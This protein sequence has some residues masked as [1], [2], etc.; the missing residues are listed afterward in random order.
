[1]TQSRILTPPLSKS[2]A[3]RALI[4]AHILQTT[5]PDQTKEAKPRDVEL[6]ESGLETLKSLNSL[7]SLKSKTIQINC[8]DGGAPFRFLL[9]QAAVHPGARVE[10]VGTRR[11]GERPHDPLIA[12]LRTI[13]GITITQ[14]VP[15]PVTVQSPQCIPSPL[16]FAIGGKE[17]SQFAS[18]LVL[19]AARL[20]VMGQ[21]ARV[22]REGPATS[23]GYFELTCSW[24]ERTGFRLER[25]SA[26]VVVKA[27]T[28]SRP[29]PSIPGDWSSLGYLLALSW[30]SGLSV[31]R[32]TL[33]TG[34][35]DEVVV[36]HLKA[37]GFEL[38]DRLQGTPSGSFDVDS[39]QCPDAIPTLA[40]L[41]T[42]LPVV[43]RFRRTEILRHK[44][45]N[46]LE[47]VC[48]L[49]WAAGAQAAVSGEVLTV[50]PAVARRFQF[51]AREDHRMAMSAAV[52]ARLHGV[53]LTLRGM[54]CVK[55]SFPGFWTEAAKAGVEVK[56]WL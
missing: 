28:E 21:Q 30:V 6:I 24:L 15:W 10:F 54:D 27:P 12:A 11:L 31:G 38:T 26:S 17:S 9:T 43:S 36:E 46:R 50:Q 25:D 37:A 47:G 34:H 2:D 5:P 8:E 18:S 42:K 35:P 22:V 3:H 1:M 29:F 19:G 55:K 48:E 13:P 56:R 14:G 7:N 51:D 33:G 20:S 49:L 23:E 32:M 40:V 44:E 53:E 45:S 4:I 52:L 39:E 16:T 41:A